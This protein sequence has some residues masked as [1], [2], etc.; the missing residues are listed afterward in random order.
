M[1]PSI[2]SADST[3]STMSISPG[4][5]VGS[6]L[7]PVTRRRNVPDDRNTSAAISHFREWDSFMPTSRIF[8]NSSGYCCSSE[9]SP[10]FFR[11]KAPLLQTLAQIETK[12]FHTVSFRP[13]ERSVRPIDHDSYPLEN[14]HLIVSSPGTPVRRKPQCRQM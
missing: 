3:R 2:T 11:T 5:T 14:S 12:A 13:P 1:S 8:M 6:M 10:R 4:H 7:H 9:T